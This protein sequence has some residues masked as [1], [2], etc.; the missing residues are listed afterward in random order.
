MNAANFSG[1]PIEAVIL[2]LDGTLVHTTVDFSRMKVRLFARMEEM[3]VP[4][5]VMDPSRTV[6][7]NMSMVHSYLASSGRIKGWEAIERL[8]GEMMQQ[9]EMERVHLT[10]PV[11][12]ARESILELRRRGL[13]VGLLTRGSRLYATAA[14]KQAGLDGILEELMFRDD[15]GE[16][17]AKPNPIA[18]RRIASKLGTN[19]EKCLMVGDHSIDST[20]AA[21]AGA[22]FV[23]VLTGAFDEEDWRRLGCCHVIGSVADLPNALGPSRDSDGANGTAGS[24]LDGEVSFLR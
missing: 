8:A 9:T 17:E 16:R 3:G 5:A 14:L 21:G 20:C 11:D 10:R 23:G 22:A 7:E 12:G 1:R 24:H 19:V 13:R 18:L 15:H 4:K 2:D 6:T